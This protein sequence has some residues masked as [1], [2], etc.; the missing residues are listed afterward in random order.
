MHVTAT[1]GAGLLFWKASKARNAEKAIDHTEDIVTVLRL[2]QADLGAAEE[3]LN[4][5]KALYA[6]EEYSRALEAAKRAE[7]I[8]VT[9]E[10]RNGAYRRATTSVNACIDEMHR[11]GLPTAP[12]EAALETAERKV[13]EGTSD[14][15]ARVP[16]Y[17][18]GRLI[19][20]RAERDG[21]DLL[22]KATAAS[23]AIFLAELAVEALLEVPGP[24]DGQAFVA[25]AGVGLERV[26]EEATRELA[27]GHAE[28]S[29]RIAKDLEERAS[30]LRSEYTEG[31]RLLSTTQ[32][33]LVALR[34]SGVDTLRYEGQIEAARRTLDRGLIG[35]GISFARRLAKEAEDLGVH[36]AQASSGLSDAE[37]LYSQLSREGFQSYEAESAIRDAH[38]AIQDG[39]FR[40]ALA[41]IQRAH[42]AFVRRRNVRETLAKSIH[43]SRARVAALHG[44]DLPF[45]P[46]VEELLTRAEREFREGEYTRSSEDLRIATLLL[47]RSEETSAGRH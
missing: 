12:L 11:L 46:D 18:E 39:N 20:E 14:R 31:L 22:Q 15:D 42:A 28:A 6:A 47:S 36:Y 3:S 44:Q 27:L 41:Q 25:G 7:S 29:V 35:P 10:E 34:T 33:R 23:N 30:R 32:A 26:L 4:T 17:L 2:T 21:R 45:I 24:T 37:S 8:A 9:L 13:R 43:E 40:R 16:N 38:V 5:A 1:K 19:L